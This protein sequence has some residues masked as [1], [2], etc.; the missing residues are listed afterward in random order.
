MHQRPR[1]LGVPRPAAER[2]GFAPERIEA[3][4]ELHPDPQVDSPMTSFSR[5]RREAANRLRVTTHDLPE[6]EHFHVCPVCGQRVDRR[7]LGDVIYHARRL[8][9][10]L[11]EIGPGDG[12]DLLT[13]LPVLHF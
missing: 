3:L 9:S 13:A 11:P 8:H 4:P 2:I 6:V 10:P 7:R 12:A 1:N 5:A